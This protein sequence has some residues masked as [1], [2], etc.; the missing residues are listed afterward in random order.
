CLSVAR[1]TSQ[2]ND[3]SFMCNKLE[4]FGGFGGVNPDPD[5]FFSSV[6]LGCLPSV[7]P[8]DVRAT[9][10]RYQAITIERS[11]NVICHHFAVAHHNDPVGVAQNLTEKM[12]DQNTAGAARNNRPH[13]LQ[14]LARRVSV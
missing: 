7:V 3:F 2:T 1:E 13:V 8:G 14:E 9:H 5:R 10:G 11:S 12:G 6:C 4:R